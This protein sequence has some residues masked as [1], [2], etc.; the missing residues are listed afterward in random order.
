[1]PLIAEPVRIAQAGYKLSWRADE[2]TRWKIL[3]NGAE[4]KARRNGAFME[5]PVALPLPK[6]TELPNA[7]PVRYQRQI[8]RA[9]CR[10][11]VCQY[12]EISVVGGTSK[13]KNIGCPSGQSRHSTHTRE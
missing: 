12:A 3:A 9:A 11:R 1:M 7:A 13:K 5:L 8:R 4:P 2:A 6:P 10:E